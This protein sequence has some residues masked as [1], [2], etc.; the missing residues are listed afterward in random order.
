MQ[1]KPLHMICDQ[2]ICDACDSSRNQQRYQRKP[3][4]N[5]TLALYFMTFVL[6]TCLLLF[7]GSDYIKK[8]LVTMEKSHSVLTVILFLC[9][10]IF[11]SFPLT[12]GY[13]LLNL[14]AGY[15]YGVVSG[16]LVVSMCALVGVTTSHFVIRRYMVSWAVMDVIVNNFRNLVTV[17]ESDHG[18]KVVVLTRL[19]PIPFGLQNALFGMCH[20]EYRDYMTASM[21]G[22]LPTQLIHAYVGS[23]LRSMQDVVSNNNNNNLAYFIF[24]CQQQQHQNCPQYRLAV[25]VDLYVDDNR[26][27]VRST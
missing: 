24:C 3:L 23:T 19:T 9:F 26:R 2:V 21:L 27:T 8:T 18:F 6:L 11:V 20:I 13:V 16:V 4:K 15:L 10:F 25:V 22:M 14:A 5:L 12:W 7:I 17:I 1:H